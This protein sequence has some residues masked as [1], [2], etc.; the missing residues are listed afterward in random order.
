MCSGLAKINAGSYAS[1]VEALTA[2]AGSFEAYGHAAPAITESV[3]VATAY[4]SGY[5]A[6][7]DYINKTVTDAEYEPVTEEYKAL[8]A[9]GEVFAA[10][11]STRFEAVSA[12]V[13]SLTD[14]QTANIDLTAVVA[15]LEL[16]EC[17]QADAQAILTN[18]AR[19][20]I[21]ENAGDITAALDYYKTVKENFEAYN[22]TAVYALEKIAVLTSKSGDLH[23]AYAFV[24]ENSGKI[25][26]D[27]DSAL[28]EEFA[29][30]LG[31]LDGAFSTDKVGEFIENA[32]AA[33]VAANYADVDVAKI[34]A[35]SGID[36]SV[37]D[38][39]K[40]YYIPLAAA[41]KA[42]QDKNL[43][44]ACAK[45]EELAMLLAEDGVALPNALLEGI[46][47]AAFNAGEL[48][49]AV[50]YCTTYVD[51]E[52]LEDGEFKS[53]CETV[54]LCSDAM[55]EATAV[56]QEAYYAGYYGSAPSRASVTEQF[57]ALL[58]EESNK[59]DRAFNYYYR[60]VCEMYFFSSEADSAAKQR[61]Y[62]EKVAE[63][64]PELMFTYAYNLTEYHIADGNFDAAAELVDKI[65]AVNAYDD[66]ALGLAAKLARINGD[67]TAAAA[68]AAKGVSYENENYEC[69]RQHIILS[70]L[71]GKY[72][73]AYDSVVALYDRGLA[74]MYE[75]ETIVI[76]EKLFTDASDEQKTKLR[77]IISY[78]ENDLYGAYGYTYAENTQA[79][80]DGTKTVND[81]FTAEPYDLW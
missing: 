74:T 41:L 34:V 21:S 22:G 19:A 29:A 12:A 3:A 72:A 46:I 6:A 2:A 62:I 55:T 63:L 73:D 38:F 27:A 70:M 14:A 67:L 40:A 56:F 51:T 42:E 57:D 58:A 50:T 23:A 59:Y 11:D 13:A 43:T 36:S 18:L 65:L 44:L 24:S 76:Y 17:V 53:L 52:S 20:I 75:C 79:I 31:T 1:A 71:N 30:L 66:I 49:Q 15:D 8:L 10:L 4:A 81:V 32:K 39:Y 80:L 68:Y 78:I 64:V 9:A 48:Q 54:M 35:D 7:L 33:L 16:P 5:A 69:E 28:T 25:A 45:Y 61:E 77:E 47:T 26:A 60:Y 37:A